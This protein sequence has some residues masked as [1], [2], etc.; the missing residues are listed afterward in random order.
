M[1]NNIDATVFVYRSKIDGSIKAMYA[2]E[3]REFDPKDHNH[4]A[5]LEPRMWIQYHFD[6]RERAAT[7]T[8][9]M[10]IDGYGTLA[11]AA[12]IRKALD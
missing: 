7:M 12:A 6:D 2:N 11:I 5:T 1:T 4:V 9:Q 8:E 10:G 3:L